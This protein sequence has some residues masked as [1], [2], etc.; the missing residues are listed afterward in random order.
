MRLKT[1]S[2][3]T[4]STAL[5]AMT[6]TAI[7]VPAFAQDQQERPSATA[8]AIEEITVTARKRE[9]NLQDTPIAISAFSAAGIEARGISNISEVGNFTPNL[10][11]RSTAAIAATSSASS[12]YIRGIGQQDWALAT[13]P[14]VGM[15]V[16]GVY[17]ARGPSAAFWT[18]LT[19]N[20]SKF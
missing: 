18:C 7:F 3:L 20:A 12:I 10:T 15:Y 5:A 8:Y 1:R 19:S 11:F 13:D 4:A 17:V 2:F 16:D 6:S 9:E 14:G